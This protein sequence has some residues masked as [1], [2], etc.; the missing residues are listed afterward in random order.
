MRQ[1]KPVTIRGTTY[2]SHAAAADAL[3]ITQQAIRSAVRF[4][5]L[6]TVG[7]NPR[8]KGHGKPITIDGV[9]YKS[10]YEAS[11]KLNIPYWSLLQ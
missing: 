5:K 4:G 8:G 6:E 2:P 9:L 1:G 10:L 11:H 3:S 7:L